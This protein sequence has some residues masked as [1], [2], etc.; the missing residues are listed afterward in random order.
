ESGPGGPFLPR[1]DAQSFGEREID[2][3]REPFEP[4]RGTLIGKSTASA[5][6][7]ERRWLP[8]PRHPKAEAISPGDRAECQRVSPRSRPSSCPP[9]ARKGRGRLHHVGTEATEEKH[10]EE[11]SSH[12]SGRQ[13]TQ[14]SGEIGG[15]SRD[16]SRGLSLSLSLS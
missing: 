16:P 2:S 15:A 3:P 7:R 12:R 13:R 9:P 5:T 1:L 8:G 14:R 6:P 4:S 10:G 11:R